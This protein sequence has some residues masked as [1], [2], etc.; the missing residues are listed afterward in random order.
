MAYQVW[1]NNSRQQEVH[2]A[3]SRLVIKRITTYIPRPILGILH[4]QN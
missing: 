2:F 1:V 4:A 3:M